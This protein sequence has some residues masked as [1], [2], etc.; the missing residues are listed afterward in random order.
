MRSLVGPLLGSCW[1]EQRECE[2]SV[3][4]QEGA[5][6]EGCVCWEDGA[7][8]HR[9]LCP[10]PCGL[11]SCWEHCSA[12]SRHH[13][14]HRHLPETGIQQ[15][16]FIPGHSRGDAAD[17]LL[18]EPERQRK[19]DGELLKSL[20]LMLDEKSRICN[21]CTCKHVDMQ[22]LS[23]PQNCPQPN[24]LLHRADVAGRVQGIILQSVE[25]KAQRD[26][27]KNVIWN[28][29]WKSKQAVSAHFTWLMKCHSPSL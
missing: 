9:E 6:C 24:P 28:G 22:L 17:P 8:A 11:E 2:R 5:V 10:C 3:P 21:A 19:A 7:G 1:K 20:S 12:C 13:L 26:A 23:P 4:A 15:D 27:K 29:G 14:D 25:C 16:A 18:S